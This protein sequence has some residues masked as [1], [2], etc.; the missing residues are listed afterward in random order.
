MADVANEKET[1]CGGCSLGQ[2][3]NTGGSTWFCGWP[4]PRL[5]FLE[6]T[7]LSQGGASET[8][9]PWDK[10]LTSWHVQARSL[11]SINYVHLHLLWGFFRSMHLALP[12]SQQLFYLPPTLP[13][14][15]ACLS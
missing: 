10:V 1:P 2:T 7:L 5:C 3:L 11:G 8:R 13:Q 4:P 6:L 14:L 12:F 15:S 9:T